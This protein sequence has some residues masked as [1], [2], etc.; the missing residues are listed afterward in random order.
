[1]KNGGD[2]GYL[3]ANWKCLFGTYAIQFDI[4]IKMTAISGEIAFFIPFGVRL[5][6]NIM[7]NHRELYEILYI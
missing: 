1:M 2:Q 7:A 5:T 6:E 4:Q 3:E